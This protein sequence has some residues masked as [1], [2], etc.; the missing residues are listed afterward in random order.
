[1]ADNALLRQIP[2]MDDLL[3]RPDIA[4]L[5]P[6]AADAARE[7]LARLR[8][9]ILAG[10]CDKLP[11]NDEIA[12]MI[13]AQVQRENTPSLRR[14][15]NATGV[16]L[17]TNLGRAP[18]ARCAIDAVSSVAGSYSTLEYSAE[19]GERGNRHSHVSGLLARL[20]GAEDALVVNN[21]AAAVLLMLAALAQ[22][23]E[24]IVSRGE[25]VEIGGSFRIPEVMEQ[26]GCILREVGATNRTRVSDY[27][28]AIHPEKTGALLKAHTSNYK[29]LGF[30]QE[31][32]VTELAALSAEHDLPFLYDLGSGPLLPLGISD[33]PHA[34]QC[35]AGGA[36]VVCFSGD[37][38]LGGPQAGIIVGKR[39]YLERMKKHPLLR[40]LRIDKLTL[41]AL[42]ATLRLYLHPERAR[43]EIPT[44]R[45]LG[46]S[47][48]ELRNAAER[49]AVLLEP[50][51]DMIEVS[52]DFGQV[53]GGCAP[54]QQLP[55][56][57][58]AISP[59]GVSVDELERRLR[60]S[61]PGIIARIA[62]DR[63]LIDPRTVDESDFEYIAQQVI[64]A[65]KEGAG[66]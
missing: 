25:L 63:L 65:L 38:L 51:S 15:I 6:G 56:A 28:A 26:S 21:N 59:R 14:L 19:L 5:L 62:K 66:K 34:A 13:A 50:V 61:S 64:A 45:M 4:A 12:A 48:Q 1:M 17:H 39:V 42:E 53:G 9:A 60:G 47:H 29:I 27:Q 49:I 10:E 24:V 22:G 2:K 8:S 41:A 55:S 11:A 32:S 7:V 57:V 23:R 52:D 35:V 33:E 36:D 37:K 46:A 18:L 30:T 20:T 31:V 43:R 58:V 44:L 16:I 40:A 3:A 54:T